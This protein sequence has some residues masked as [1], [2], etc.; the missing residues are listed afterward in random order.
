MALKDGVAVRSF[1]TWHAQSAQLG[2][3]SVVVQNHA[4]HLVAFQWPDSFRSRAS[5]IRCTKR[6][7]GADLTPNH[8]STVVLQNVPQSHMLTCPSTVTLRAKSTIFT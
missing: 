8:R 3:A 4:L 6:W 7:D 2:I 1:D 5:P